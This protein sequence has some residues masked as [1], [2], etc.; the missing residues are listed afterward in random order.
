MKVQ[1]VGT[2][3]VTLRQINRKKREMYRMAKRFGMTHPTVV[4]CSQEL[5]EL[6]NSYQ[7]IYLYHEVI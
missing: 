3:L 1:T 2:E 4:T 6:L 5:D 7:G